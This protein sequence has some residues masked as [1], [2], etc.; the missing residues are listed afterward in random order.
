MRFVII[1]KD[2]QPLTD[3]DGKLIAL[4]AREAAQRW[5]APGERIEAWSDDRLRR[6]KAER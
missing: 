4:E 1:A 2:G 6:W 5:A 3:I